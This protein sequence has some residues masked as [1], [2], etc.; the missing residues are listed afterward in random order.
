MKVRDQWKRRESLLLKVHFPFHS[1]FIGVEITE[2]LVV[3][4]WSLPDGKRSTDETCK[5]RSVRK[6]LQKHESVDHRGTID[7]RSLC[8][9]VVPLTSITRAPRKRTKNTKK[10][11][12]PLSLFFLL[13]VCAIQRNT[14]LVSLSLLPCH[15]LIFHPPQM[16]PLTTLVFI[17]SLSCTT[18]M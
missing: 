9:I 10:T 16:N 13:S 2:V 4:H 11:L 8:V 15:W 7:H 12:S 3:L 14:H 17:F 5:C 18:C 6:S 1:R